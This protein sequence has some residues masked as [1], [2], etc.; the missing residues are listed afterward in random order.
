[1]CWRLRLARAWAAAARRHR[2]S[3]TGALV[4][5]AAATAAGSDIA[6]TFTNTRLPTITLTKISNGGVGGFIFNGD[7]GFGAAQTIT[8]VTSGV[9]V[10]GATRTLAAASTITTITET[11]PAGYVLASATCTGMG[12]GGTATPNLGNRCAGAQCSGNGCRF[13][14]RL[15][16]HQYQAA[17]HHADQDQQWRGW[18]LHL[19]WRQWLWRGPDDH[20][21]DSGVGVTGATRTLAAASTITTIT[22]TIPAG[23]VLASVTCTGM[24]GGGT[25]TPNLATGAVVLN[26]AATAAGSDIA[27]TFTNTRLPTVTLT[28]ISNGGVGGFTFNGDN[29][30][31]AA[32]RSP[33]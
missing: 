3:A 17:H 32:R 19:Q 15:H 20:H 9:G 11:I 22:E 1:M 12:G 21:G 4:L 23:Y 25:A 27:C 28:K 8:T 31:G 30:F 18:R 13:R 26:A 7:N 24:G 16:L 33:R 29:G 6:C 14:H 10:T 5:N 2:T